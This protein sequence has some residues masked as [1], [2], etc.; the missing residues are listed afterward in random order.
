MKPF[1][2]GVLLGCLIFVAPIALVVYAYHDVQLHN[3]SISAAN[4][5]RI[6]NARVQGTASPVAC[7]QVKDKWVVT[8]ITAN[9]LVRGVKEGWSVSRDKQQL[10][11]GS[12]IAQHAT[13]DAALITFIS[14]TAIDIIPIEARLPVFGEKVWAVGYPGLKMPIITQGIVSHLFLASASSYNGCSGGPVIDS[15]GRV[16]GIVVGV[17]GYR[18]NGKVD[19]VRHIMK[20][21]PAVSLDQWLTAHN[22]SH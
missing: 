17:L 7:R 3:P 1:V 13:E 12:L 5:W 14:A 18:R 2:V 21:T 15:R 8:F 20:F 9:H 10:T 22:I 6:E 19:T 4:V 11:G 16:I